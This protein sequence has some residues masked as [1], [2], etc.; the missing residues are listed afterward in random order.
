MSKKT[1]KKVL[2]IGLGSIGKKH[3]QILKTIKPSVKVYRLLR[4]SSQKKR[5][6]GIDENIYSLDEALNKDLDMAI[7]SSPSSEHLKYV[8]PLAHSGVNLLIEK[9][10]SNS[11]KKI[12]L[13][14]DIKNKFSIKILTGYN[15]R[16][17]KSL[18]FFKRKIQSGY[19]GKINS[20]ESKVGQNLISWRKNQD[21][22]KTV[23]AIESLGGGVLLELSHEIDYLNWI[24]GKLDW[25]SAHVEKSSDMEIKVEDTV[26]A[27]LRFKKNQLNPKGFSGFLK[28]DMF[29]DDHTRTCRVDG[30]KK[31]IMWD[32]KKNK[33]KEFSIK[34]NRWK[35]IYEDKCSKDSSY[36]NQLRYFINCIEDDKSI[37]HRLEDSIEVLKIIDS[38]RLS[39][40]EKKAINLSL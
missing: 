27:I 14:K 18:N 16:F 20:L 32:G 10:L 40:K 11:L 30:S 23:S 19:I 21:Y 13:I 12:D 15:L 7:I 39:S 31:T 5:F 22:K 6:P 24:F 8:L 36:I 29:R 38:I 2:L 3:I 4:N 17:L 33:V 28:M 1:V 26:N 34:E 9:P 35:V 37:H 25:V